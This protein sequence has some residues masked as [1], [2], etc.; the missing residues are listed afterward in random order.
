[1]W[2]RTGKL[3]TGQS[4]SL[5]RTME[6]REWQWKLQRFVCIY[7]IRSN[8]Q[9]PSSETLGKMGMSFACSDFRDRLGE[10]VLVMIGQWYS[11][12]PLTNNYKCFSW[13]NR[14][15]KSICQKLVPI[16]LIVLEW[17]IVGVTINFLNWHVIIYIQMTCTTLYNC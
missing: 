2:L 14:S 16:P 4:L 3:S 9:F 1:M 12:Q 11:R 10:Q 8:Y 6:T 17:G 13:S 15:Q 5:S 7:I